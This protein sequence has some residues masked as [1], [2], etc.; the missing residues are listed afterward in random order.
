MQES[1]HDIFNDEQ[2]RNT[3][4]LIGVTAGHSI[5]FSKEKG[6]WSTTRFSN[7]DTLSLSLKRHKTSD[8]HVQCFYQLKMCGTQ[9]IDT[10]ID[11][12][13]RATVS[14][15]NEIV[16]KSQMILKRLIFIVCF[17]GKGELAFRAHDE[18]SSPLNKVTILIHWNS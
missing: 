15:H 6:P 16:K 9:R 2:Y 11:S 5:L 1:T 7:L 10:L 17:L 8:N 14:R 13:A 18:S 3:L 12:Q 4:W